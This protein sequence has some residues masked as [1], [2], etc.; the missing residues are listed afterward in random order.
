MQGFSVNFIESFLEYKQQA[1]LKNLTLLFYGDN[2]SKEFNSVEDIIFEKTIGNINYHTMKRHGGISVPFKIYDPW[3]LYIKNYRNMISF[4]EYNFS[5]YMSNAESKKLLTKKGNQIILKNDFFIS[6]DD[7]SA[8][9]F[10]FGNK[11]KTGYLFDIDTNVRSQNRKAITQKF[12]IA[13][14][15]GKMMINVDS[16]SH[17]QDERRRHNNDIG[18]YVS[19]YPGNVVSSLGVVGIDITLTRKNEVPQNVVRIL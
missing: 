6:L 2:S 11:N 18:F 12:N 3:D 19:Q 1:Q 14:N 7:S 15:V 8:N 16:V 13:Q 4:N 10:L 17:T 5:N 9:Y